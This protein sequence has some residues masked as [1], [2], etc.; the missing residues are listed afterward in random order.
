MTIGEATAQMTLD[1][2]IRVAR[3]IQRDLNAGRLR[4][5]YPEK[6]RLAIRVCMSVFAREGDTAVKALAITARLEAETDPTD[7]VAAA[8]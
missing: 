4:V 5:P 1:D 3:S 2:A 6:V 7:V 8:W